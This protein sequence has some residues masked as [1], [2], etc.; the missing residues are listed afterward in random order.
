MVMDKSEV[1]P[2]ELLAH[3]KKCSLLCWNRMYLSYGHTACL[4][5]QTAALTPKHEG[6][7]NLPKV[8]CS[9]FSVMSK[10]GGRK[11]PSYLFSFF[12]PILSETR[13]MQPH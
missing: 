9:L 1:S 2:T 13:F 8:F 3:G 11:F 7:W 5:K 6:I 12:C 4:D 10:K